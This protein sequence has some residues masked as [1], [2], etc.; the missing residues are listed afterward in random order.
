MPSFFHYKEA[1]QN[2]AVPFQTR[3]KRLL[4]LE[5]LPIGF[6]N[7]LNS[8][9][10]A[11]ALW[12]FWSCRSRRRRDGLGPGAFGGAARGDAATSSGWDWGAQNPQTALLAPE[13]GSASL[14]KT[15]GILHAQ[16]S[17]PSSLPR[18][19]CGPDGPASPVPKSLACEPLPRRDPQRPRLAPSALGQRRHLLAEGALGTGLPGAGGTPFAVR[20][21]P[22]PG[23]TDPAGLALGP[24][25]LR[26]GDGGRGGG[27]SRA[28]GG[29]GVRGRRPRGAYLPLPTSWCRRRAAR[30]P[31]FLRSRRPQPQGQVE[32]WKGL[33]S[34]CLASA[35]RR[36]GAEQRAEAREEQ[37]PRAARVG[38][39]GRQPSPRAQRRA[40]RRKV[41]E[42]RVRAWRGPALALGPARCLRTLPAPR[43][44]RPAAG[45]WRGDSAGEFGASESRSDAG[46][47]SAS[48][49]FK[50][51]KHLPR[52]PAG[53]AA[54]A[55]PPCRDITPLLPGPARGPGDESQSVR[56]S[57]R[58]G[59][60]L[61]GGRGARGGARTGRG[62]HG[63]GGRTGRGAHGRGVHGKGTGAQG[64]EQGLR[65]QGRGTLGLAGE[66]G[67]NGPDGT[68][69]STRVSGESPAPLEK[70]RGA[71]AGCGES[72]A[73]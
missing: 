32:T 19:L 29:A 9:C 16:G 8:G 41:I 4:W 66:T 26:A 1:A 58:H 21:A 22:L 31:K 55:P 6:Q 13:G 12:V 34:W 71:G 63:E 38:S 50:A 39:P 20:A 42:G 40:P 45:I 43:C 57:P 33:E 49:L 69:E 51:G 27:A 10:A 2:L 60:R 46:P 65:G 18:A 64:R 62:A 72:P 59:S 56:P 52:L 44:P 7:G 28:V 11:A 23:R 53:P 70:G 37:A 68:P 35:R 61:P 24:G 48:C 15:R 67:A 30:A 54:P 5:L 36:R 17:L 14:G 73:C 3:L 25:P 47:R